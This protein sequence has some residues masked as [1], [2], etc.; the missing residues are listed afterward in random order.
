LVHTLREFLADFGPTLAILLMA[1]IAFLAS[2]AISLDPLP[3]PDHVQ[4]TTGRSW[5]VPFAETP[6]WVIWLSIVPA[7]L[8]SLLVFLDQNITARL[9]NSPDNNLQKGEAYHLDL[10]VVGVLIAACSIFGLPWL[11]AATV[12]SLNH[13]RSLATT[14]DIVD[15]AGASHTHILHVR[16]NR[17]TGVA[18]HLL[19]GISLLLLPL[20]KYIPLSVLFGLFLYMGVVSMKGNQFFERLSLWAT[21]PALYPRTHFVRRVPWRVM[22]VFT[23]IQ[24]VCLVVLWFVK[25][26][27][28]GLL[29]PL[30]VAML[31]PVRFLLGKLF[32]PQYLAALDAEENPEEEEETWL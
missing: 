8:C 4:T 25:T 24:L 15:K 5:L 1:V 29:F 3:A 21:D 10:L 16:E 6:R 23:V 32:E 27:A 13:V 31:V 7:L 14:E 9:V 17:L 28:W 19:I 22:H 30:F 12:R 26:S 2:D 11:V 18:I 20:I